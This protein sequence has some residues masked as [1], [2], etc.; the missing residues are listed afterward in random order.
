M[1]LHPPKEVLGDQLSS[2]LDKMCLHIYERESL[3]WLPVS[4]LQVI[5]LRQSHEDSIKSGKPE[6]EVYKLSL[7]VEA[8][9]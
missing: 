3:A 2:L 9:Q 7:S 5:A 8:I 1:H 6:G 4:Y